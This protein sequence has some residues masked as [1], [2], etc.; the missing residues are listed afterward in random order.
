MF[1]WES[2]AVRNGEKMQVPCVEGDALGC[3][4]AVVFGVDTEDAGLDAVELDAED[5]PS[6]V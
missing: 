6:V 2:P 4:S 3:L 5:P 1:F